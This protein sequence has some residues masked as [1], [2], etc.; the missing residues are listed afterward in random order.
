M[1]EGLKEIIERVNIILSEKELL[2]DKTLDKEKLD[3]ILSKSKEKVTDFVN[4]FIY[5]GLKDKTPKEDMINTINN[6]CDA[7]KEIEATACADYLK[8]LLINKLDKDF[9]K[10]LLRLKFE[11]FQAL[12]YSLIFIVAIIGYKFYNNYDTTHPILSVKGL[13]NAISICKKIDRHDSI[14]DAKTHAKGS[15]WGKLILSWPFKPSDEEMKYYTDYIA[16]LSYVIVALTEDGKIC[17]SE[18]WTDVKDVE[19]V[20]KDVNKINDFI[21]EE[22]KSVPLD[23]SNEDVALLLY[24]AAQKTF[25]CNNE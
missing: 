18:H 1:D 3:D 4:D 9:G 2:E 21:A 19:K 5:K 8:P 7:L 6:F 12:I 16:D 15:G 20:V 22:I 25:P 14:L 10:S 11:H 24:N 13:N 23:A 17:K